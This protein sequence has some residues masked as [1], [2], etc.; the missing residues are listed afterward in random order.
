VIRLCDLNWGLETWDLGYGV[1]FYF[2]KAH[3]QC[4]HTKFPKR[5]K[6]LNLA[7]TSIIDMHSIT[8]HV[9][10]Y[11]HPIIFNEFLIHK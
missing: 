7:F 5:N 11:K 6:T 2:Y 4:K 8:K 3:Q 1:F 10:N 9:E